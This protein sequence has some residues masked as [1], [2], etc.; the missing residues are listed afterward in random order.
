VFYLEGLPLDRDGLRFEDDGEAAALGAAIM[1]AYS[2]LGYPL[3]HVPAFAGL[4]VQ[5]A[6]ERR[7]ALI[8]SAVG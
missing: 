2:T 3:V 5:A 8:L 6:I 7:V 1:A 4:P